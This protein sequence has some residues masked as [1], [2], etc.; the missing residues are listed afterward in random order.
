MEG[1]DE[2]RTDNNKEDVPKYRGVKAMPFIIGNETFEKLGTM[3]T[4]SNLIVYL[5]TV[6]NMKSITATTVINVF[7]GTVNAVPLIGAFV[8]DTYLGRY[9]TLA[10]ASIC[11]FM[12]MIVLTLTAGISKLHPPR[13]TK[14]EIGRCVGVGATGGQL[15]LLFCG[16][17]FL[18]LG[19][20][21]I[22]PCNL[23]FGADQF[24]PNTESGKRGINSFF[25]WYY[26]TY[27]F[28]MMISTTFI[29]Y[30]QSNVN[31]TLGLAIPA[32]L[33]FMSCA[34][35]F[36]GTK[37]YVIV[38]PEGSA[39]LSVVQVLVAAA[40]KQKLRQ[41]S[42]PALS[43]FNYMPANSIN[44][45]LPYTNQFR[46][47][48]KAAIVTDEDQFNSDG[49]AANPWKL[50]SIQQVE[51]AKC[52]LRVIPIWAT[53]IIYYVPVVQQNTYAVLQS[54]QADRRIG[55]NGFEIPA[56]SIIVFAMLT[57]TIFIPIYDRIIVPSL[58]KITGKEG[59]I[60]ILQRM[61]IGLIFSILTMI[62]SGLIEERRRRL[63]ITGSTGISPKGGVISS[64]SAL[65]LIPQLA[66]AGLTEALNSVG[67][68]EF[69]YKQFPEN[70]RSIAGSFFYLGLAGSF[71]LSSILVSIVHH[72]TAGSDGRNWLAED[73]NKARLDLFYYMIAVLGALNFGCF[74]V[75]AKFYRYK[76]KNASEVVDGCGEEV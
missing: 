27:T 31:W 14:N 9:K 42:Y 56:A 16:L 51:E 20:G 49:S 59:G 15:A 18:V 57:L 6:F 11:S 35:F 54:L 67:Q 55:N 21:G 24:N 45:K 37:L 12:G 58:R 73:L 53:G 48:D 68:T 2:R 76:G 13:C 36:F 71:Y 41:P 52:V 22:R 63:A 74:L 32:G 66:L 19:A 8:S 75:F 40:K 3:G 34:L 28:G 70:M 39:I 26:C 7:T 29:V 23:A 1:K 62:V 50:C 43:L 17:G 10:F 4:V 25:N 46:W 72:V 38:K 64:M 30:V 44:S 65:W 69:Y 61:G 47:L 5:T 60:T 33:M